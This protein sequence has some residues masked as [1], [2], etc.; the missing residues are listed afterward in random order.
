M[1]LDLIP[2]STCTCN[3]TRPAVFPCAVLVSGERRVD[4]HVRFFPHLS[5]GVFLVPLSCE[6]SL[7]AVLPDTDLLCIF[8][9]C[10][11][12][13]GYNE[14][15]LMQ[16]HLADIVQQ[17]GI[18]TL[19]IGSPSCVSLHKFLKLVTTLTTPGGF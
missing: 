1:L 6:L 11:D 10:K 17:F 14:K 16:K 18:L 12:S 3:G 8:F 5:S 7:C 13:C 9:S 2:S 4:G 19:L 15:M